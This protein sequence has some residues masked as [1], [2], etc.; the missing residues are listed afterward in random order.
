M[1]DRNVLKIVKIGFVGNNN[2]HGMG[3][4]G[5]SGMLLANDG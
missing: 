2:V 3:C 1:K 4:F 5:K